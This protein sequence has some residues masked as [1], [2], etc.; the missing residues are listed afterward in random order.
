MT[1]RFACLSDVDYLIENDIHISTDELKTSV[2]LK[3]IIVAEL[4]G[5]IIGWLRYNFFWD[6]TP[7]MNMLV[8]E[9]KYR[10]KGYGRKTVTFW[11]DEM[12]NQGH[13]LVLTSTQ[14]DE[15]AQHFYRKLHYSDIG[16]FTLK[17][18]PLEIILAKYL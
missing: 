2:G 17:D 13:K 12:K 6:N 18:E 4:E 1:I 14:S 5:K 3:R 10:F 15:Q 9:E 16:G 7:F 8:F 11:E